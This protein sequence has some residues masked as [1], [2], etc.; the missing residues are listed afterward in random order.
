MKSEPGTA[1]L[2]SLMEECHALHGNHS[3]FAC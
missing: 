3:F 2:H 1:S